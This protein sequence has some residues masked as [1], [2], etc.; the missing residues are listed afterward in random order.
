MTSN[1]A[2]LKTNKLYIYMTKNS[3]PKCIKNSY[4]SK[5][6]RQSN[7]LKCTKDLDTSQRKIYK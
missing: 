5:I 2:V 3:N 4:N 7:F 6:K 1:K